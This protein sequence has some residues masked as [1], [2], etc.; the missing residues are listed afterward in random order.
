MTGTRSSGVGWLALLLV[1]GMGLAAG[2]TV[3]EA[4][5]RESALQ[6]RL[7]VL[8]NT[9]AQES[10]G[11]AELS[12]RMERGLAARNSKAQA[13]VARQAKQ[14]RGI[15]ARLSAQR[16]ELSRFGA[17]DRRDWLLAEAQYLLR[18]ANQRLIMADDVV[19]AEALLSSAD[20]ILAELDD[21][22][23]HP[24]RLAVAADL[25]ALR[26]V[27][28][29]DTEGMYLRL[30]ALIEQTASLVIFQLP[31]IQAPVAPQPA[32]NWQE[33]LQQGYRAALNKLSDYIIIRRRDVPMQAL[34]DPQWEGLVR[35]NLRMLL[36]QAQVALL[37]GNQLLFR[38]SLQ[39]SNHWV[40]EF[41]QSD[42]AAA[43]AMAEAIATLL[44]ENIAPGLPDISRSL[45]AINDVM[46]QRLRP[47]G[48]E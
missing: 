39:R 43:K 19:A 9:A 10:A 45:S 35:Q 23:L 29:Y 3:M 27:P 8:E 21:V 44:T 47:S 41:F 18:L 34:M 20:R 36:E 5:R 31:D 32:Q 25:A 28:R 38:E 4:Q 30:S 12:E 16:E 42:E 46:N 6:A 24:V 11:L 2:W 40:A 15:E 17:T 37:S 1:V 14:L 7:L 48:S 26:A 13:Q 33:R 22:R